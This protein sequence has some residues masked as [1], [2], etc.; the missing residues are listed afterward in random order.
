[1]RNAARKVYNYIEVRTINIL[2]AAIYDP[3]KIV[4]IIE[5]QKSLLNNFYNGLMSCVLI[6]YP[7]VFNT[8]EPRNDSVITFLIITVYIIPFNNH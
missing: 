2:Y 6:L 4:I 8:G 1:M 5:N 7:V 3:I